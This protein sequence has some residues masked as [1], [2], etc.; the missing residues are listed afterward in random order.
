MKMLLSTQTK[1]LGR[2]LG[3]EQA[4]KMIAQ[5]G[6]DAYDFSMGRIQYA[7]DETSPFGVGDAFYH[8]DDYAEKIMRLKEIADSLGIVCNQA[9]G[10]FPSRKYADQKYSEKTFEM[11]IRSMECASLLGAK[12][13]VMHPVKDCPLEVDAFE[14]NIAFFERLIPY[15]RKYDIV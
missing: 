1:L 9:H 13:I 15:C 14:Y 2:K 12:Q 5:A 6:F 10:P 3:Q 11:I 4:I 8:F 7:L